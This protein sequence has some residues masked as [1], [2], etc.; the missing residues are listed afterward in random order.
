MIEKVASVVRKS[1]NICVAGEEELWTWRHVQIVVSS[2]D[3]V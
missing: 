2:S 3:T 1:G